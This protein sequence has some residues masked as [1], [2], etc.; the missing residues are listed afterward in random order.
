MTVTLVE[1]VV[2]KG[3]SRIA[4]RAHLIVVYSNLYNI[5]GGVDEKA[6]LAVHS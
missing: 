2:V 3:D 5:S 1:Y 4:L 6:R